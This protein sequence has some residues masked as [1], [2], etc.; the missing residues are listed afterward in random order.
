MQYFSLKM[1]YVMTSVMTDNDLNPRIDVPQHEYALV[2]F[3][4][5][6]KCVSKN[7]LFL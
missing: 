2:I 3:F 1:E 7:L 4:K 6:K 5:I